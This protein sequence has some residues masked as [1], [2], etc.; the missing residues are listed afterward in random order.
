ML[1]VLKKSKKRAPKKRTPKSIF[2]QPA[3]CFLSEIDEKK[4]RKRL[5]CFILALAIILVITPVLFFWKQHFSH[6]LQ[7]MSSEKIENRQEQ[8]M[9]TLAAL[10]Y[11]H[12]NAYEAY[13]MRHDYPMHKYPKSFAVTFHKEMS[14][15]DKRAKEHGRSLEGLLNQVNRQFGPAFD[16]VLSKELKKMRDLLAQRQ[17]GG[18]DKNGAHKLSVTDVCRLLDEHADIILTNPQIA[19]FILIR[20]TAQQLEV[21]VQ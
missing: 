18:I 17:V 5:S 6:S 7:W 9:M 13:C 14:V 4:R 3:D 21:S 19:D 8:E 12:F 15:L 20:K 10:I 16:R 1:K 2:K 11:R